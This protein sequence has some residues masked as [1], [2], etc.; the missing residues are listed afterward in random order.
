A[1]RERWTA[2]GELVRL[3]VEVGWRVPRRGAA[4]DDGTIGV[5]GAEVDPDLLLELSEGQVVQAIAWPTGEEIRP[6]RFDGFGPGPKGSWRLGKQP[7]GRVRARIEAPL[8]ASL[9]V[10]AGD[11]VVSMPIV[12]ILERPQQ[13]AAPV[14]LAVSVER[15][16]WDS[17]VVDLGPSGGD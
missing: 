6:D 9:I 8:E 17:L 15:L 13:T 3:T 12:T 2:G 10:R 4:Q 1:A 11:Q 14:P 16:P 7:E 5:S